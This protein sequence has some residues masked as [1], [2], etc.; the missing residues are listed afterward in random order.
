MNKKQSAVIVAILVMALTQTLIFAAP[1]RPAHTHCVSPI[2]S[3]AVTPFFGPVPF[4]ANIRYTITGI[5]VGFATI[6]Y[7]DGTS[8]TLPTDVRT[9][10]VQHLYTV[11]GAYT[12][13]LFVAND[14]GG[15]A[16]F[17]T[18]YATP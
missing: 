12:P 18:V 17:V 13:L 4:T 15:F 8:D 9:G 7:G 3:M 10:F 14:C 16:V 6:D 11:P 1:E 5:P 2:C